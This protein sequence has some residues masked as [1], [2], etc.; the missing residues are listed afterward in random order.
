MG[1]RVG[2]VKFDGGS[3][4]WAGFI[5]LRVGVVEFDGGSTVWMGFY[6]A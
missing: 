4:V 3:S 5:G 2:F 1:L 6:R